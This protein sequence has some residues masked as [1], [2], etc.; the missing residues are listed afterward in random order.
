MKL[1]TL[2][3]I[4]EELSHD[5]DLGTATLTR[6]NKK[7]TPGQTTTTSE[8][9]KEATPPGDFE[10]QDA[11]DLQKLIANPDKE[12]ARKNYGSVDRYIAMLKT[13]LAGKL[14]KEETIHESKTLEWY[15]VNPGSGRYEADG[16]KTTY[17]ILR[18]SPGIFAI[19]IAGVIFKIVKFDPRDRF[20]ESKGL[21]Q[22]K[23][24]AQDEAIRRGDIQGKLK[25]AIT[26]P[27]PGIPTSMVTLSSS[28]KLQ[29]KNGRLLVNNHPFEMTEPDESQDWP[30]SITPMGKL[31]TWF[32]GRPS[33]VNEWDPQEISGRFEIVFAAE[34]VGPL[35]QIA[36][37]EVDQKP[38]PQ[39][40][41]KEI[42]KV[43]RQNAD[44]A[45]REKETIHLHD[46][47]D[48][49]KKV[50][51]PALQKYA[52]EVTCTNPH[53]EDASKRNDVLFKK[54]VIPAS[55]SGDAVDKAKMKAK[56][57]GLVVRSAK[58]DSVVREDR[59]C[60]AR[61]IA[62]IQIITEEKNRSL[63]ERFI[64]EKTHDRETSNLDIAKQFSRFKN[65]NK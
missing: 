54:Y 33:Q 8:L 12:F 62:R 23:K 26:M 57:A 5:R 22:A 49:D 30:K 15:V 28:D 9:T 18:T 63:I 19:K 64:S 1:K 11:E 43:A 32:K 38:I 40:A 51:V 55:S 45:K 41:K 2:K 10:K 13:K 7:V 65:L 14:T 58:Y 60:A 61:E 42:S 37:A 20:G 31:V 50:G 29:V 25:E 53:N 44:Q 6:Q 48:Q 47:V 35:A 4:V 17:V 59:L 16:F 27:V 34:S 21:T 3:S 52:I 56:E 24:I 36:Q 39:A 46:A